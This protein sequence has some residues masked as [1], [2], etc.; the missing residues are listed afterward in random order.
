MKKKIALF[1]I[2]ATAFAS[3]FA[4]QDTSK[5]YLQFPDIPPFT[6]TKA[7]DSSS[8]SKQ[9]LKK[10]KP[11]LIMLFSPDCEH[12]QRQTTE[13][14]KDIE[15]IK[16]VQIVMVSFLNYDLIQKFYNEYGIAKFP[17]IHMGRDGKYFL[18]TFYKP[19]IFPS[20]FLYNKKGKLVNFFEGN[21][22]AKQ[23]AENL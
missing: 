8:F 5:L 14:K 9:D 19:H 7:P 15:L 18:G 16:K 2:F 22:S 10:K 13:F 4:Q 23:I 20:M 21:V 12:C 11:V 17:N 1:I 3:S 6:I